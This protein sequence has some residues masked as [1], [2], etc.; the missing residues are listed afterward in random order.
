MAGLLL[1]AG[2]G[3]RMGTP[4]ALLRDPDGTAW[5]TRSARTLRDGGCHP[6]LVVVGA[7]AEQVVALLAEQAPDGVRTVRAGDWAEGMG[8]SLRAGL[9]AVATIDGGGAGAVDAVLVGL[10]DTPG[11]NA[12]VVTRLRH[13]AAGRQVLA[14]AGYHGRPGHPVLIGRLHWAGA[15]A[16]ARGDAG[17]RE[18]LAGRDDVRLIE[19]ADLGDGTD[20]DVPTDLPGPAAALYPDEVTT[21]ARPLP[22]A[23]H[24]ALDPDRPTTRHSHDSSHLRPPAREVVL[25]VVTEAPLE[26]ADH[27]AAVDRGAAGAVVSFRGVV[28][29]HDGGRPV[30]AIEYVAHP[31]A[32]AV[33][34]QVVTELAP[35]TDCEAIA[36]SHRVGQLK[37]GD[38]A[39]V[40]AVSAAHR[41]EAFAAAALIVDEVKHRLPVWK[42]QQFP[43]GSDEWVACP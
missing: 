26:V 22:D 39:I 5:V 37:V 14:R 36:V 7:A 19:C 9:A 12:G 32:A 4:K 1:A 31:S 8:A 20:R 33:L 24:P 25:A 41:Q 13:A 3:R 21:Q 11:V 43:D 10:V 29:D 15:A 28:R 27:E 18:Y 23:P 2:S 30:T 42:R 6:V 34:S 40:V 16:A 17:A 38:S 35:R